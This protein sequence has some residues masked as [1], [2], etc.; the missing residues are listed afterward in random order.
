MTFKN[1]I[2]L[3]ISFAI[4]AAL[5]VTTYILLDKNADK[6]FS[7]SKKSNNSSSFITPTLSQG[8]DA[9]RTPKINVSYDEILKDIIEE[10][11]YKDV[12]FYS[13]QE[14]K[15]SADE[16]AV[17]KTVIDLIPQKLFDYKPWAI[18][19]TTIADGDEHAQNNYGIAYSGGPFVFV[20]DKTFKKEN[21]NDN[22]TFRGLLRIMSHEFTH[23]AQFFE[24][25]ESDGDKISLDNSL[26][27]QKWAEKTGWSKKGEQWLLD[28]NELTTDY[29]KTNPTED[30]ADAVGQLVI[31]DEASL[32]LSR[33]DWVLDW[34]E[35]SK[36][37][38]YS[39]TLPNF[40]KLNQIK[41]EEADNLKANSYID[42]DSIQTDIL[43]FQYVSEVD[44]SNFINIFVERLKERGWTEISSEA[45]AFAYKRHYKINLEIDNNSLP[46]I[47]IVM[48]TY[49]TF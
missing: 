31:G 12:K 5:P 21:K 9:L 6:L 10:D 44:N 35:T 1:S 42:T 23:V 38:L 28:S 33:I 40:E 16:I 39:G 13:T 19:S 22:G 30:M 4:L 14:R 32:S 3:I 46:V 20:G 27:T 18:I 48:T 7:Q 26:I 24:T 2:K 41:L 11:Q 45:G 8:R 34:L 29:G 36:S 49:P 25:Y 43:K 37:E 17:L 47:L 15:F